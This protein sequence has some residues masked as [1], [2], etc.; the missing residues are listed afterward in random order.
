MMIARRGPLTGE[1]C[2]GGAGCTFAACRDLKM[3][4]A[5]D[6]IL[7]QPQRDKQTAR[8]ESAETADNRGATREIG[9]S[10]S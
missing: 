5:A 4:F 7:S 3:E 8:H 9:D 6:L 2:S 10:T 1:G